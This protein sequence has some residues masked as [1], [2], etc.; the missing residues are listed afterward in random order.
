MQEKDEREFDAVSVPVADIHNN[1]DQVV[2]RI[3]EDKLRLILGEYERDVKEGRSWIAPLGIC[4]TVVVALTTG[5]DNGTLPQGWWQPIHATAC[6]YALAWL[7][8]TLAKRKWRSRPG[9]DAVVDSM[10][11]TR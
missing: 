5:T 11:S 2:I 10:K 9:I 3:T 4:I 7:I 6:L 1:V 8:T